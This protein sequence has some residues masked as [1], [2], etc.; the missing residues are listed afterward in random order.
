[1]AGHNGGRR[2]GV[3]VSQYIANLNKEPSAFEVA[4]SEE[5][6]YGVDDESLAQ[7]TNTD[8]F[9]FDGADFLN[10]S[11]GVVRGMGFGDDAK[12]EKRP[13]M[14]GEKTGNDLEYANGA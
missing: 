14:D 11:N 6:N 12:D 5:Q 7:F 9:D 2:N 10:E 4:T 3:N 1:M 13:S 8:F